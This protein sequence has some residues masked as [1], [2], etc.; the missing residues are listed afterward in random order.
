[1]SASS[2]AGPTAAPSAAAAAAAASSS[3]S[4]PASTATAEVE[5]DPFQRLFHPNLPGETQLLFLI[6]TQ[7]PWLEDGLHVAD[8]TEFGDPAFDE[9]A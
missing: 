4:S 8:G 5:F 2:R 7:F 3:S 6:G 1:M 9:I